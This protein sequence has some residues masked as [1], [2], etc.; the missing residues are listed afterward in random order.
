MSLTK[1]M[2]ENTRVAVVQDSPVVFNLE[3]TLEK[4]FGLMAAAAAQGAQLVLF[5]EGFIPAYPVGLDFGARFGFRRPRGRQEFERYFNSAIEIPGPVCDRLGQAARE[6][7]LHLVMGIIERDRGT[8]YCSVAF[9]APDG[10]LLGKRRKLM[11]TALERVVW[12][13]GDGAT[14]DV[15]ETRIGRLGAV[16]CWENYMPSL[17]MHMYSQGIQIY[18]APT[19]DDLETWCATLR[20]IA[21][22]GGCFVL[23]ACQYLTRSDYPEYLSPESP[24]PDET[25]DPN[26]V[27]MKGGSCIVDPMGSFLAG[28]DFDG[29]KILTADLNLARIARA[30]Y[31]LDVAGHYARPD[32]FQLR[33]NLRRATSVDAS[34]GWAEEP[35]KEE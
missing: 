6:Y 1:T 20:H 23:G 12:G 30:K 7:S 19:A 18:C 4:A 3:A 9:W 28:P 17:R 15:F 11:P 2:P 16:I 10:R 33:V 21:R 8:L 27:L 24:W 31:D 13:M 34:S 26:P 29:R 25:D 22:E 32:I 35:F 14:M 5:P